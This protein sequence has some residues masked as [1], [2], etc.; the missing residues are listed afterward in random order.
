MSRDGFPTGTNP[1]ASSGMTIKN[2]RGY[3]FTDFLIED[4]FVP[5]QETKNK[6]MPKLKG[7]LRPSKFEG[8]LKSILSTGTGSIGLFNQR[9]WIYIYIEIYIPTNS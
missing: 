2:Y 7:T 5:P 8:T 6:Y 1:I 4:G 9:I 3:T